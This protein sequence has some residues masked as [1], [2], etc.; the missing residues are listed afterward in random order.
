[1]DIDSH[2]F[3]K[4]GDTYKVMGEPSRQ[5]GKKG[6]ITPNV[7]NYKRLRELLW[8]MGVIRYVLG[9]VAELMMATVLLLVYAGIAF[10]V[11]GE[12]AFAALLAVVALWVTARVYR[13][14]VPA[15]FTR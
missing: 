1:M 15:R 13:Q 9:T 10:A 2:T 12:G 4:W 11:F 7:E 3:L 6:R 8:V 14:D 5:S